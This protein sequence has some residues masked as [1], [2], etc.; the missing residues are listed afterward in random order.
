MTST[1]ECTVDTKSTVPLAGV[2]YAPHS[3]WTDIK[4]LL[5]CVATPTW[6]SITGLTVR[7]VSQ[8]TLCF[9]LTL[10]L[11]GIQLTFVFVGN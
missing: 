6:S 5:I 11:L 4:T 1:L 7:R 9:L 3:V 10:R 8:E 2:L